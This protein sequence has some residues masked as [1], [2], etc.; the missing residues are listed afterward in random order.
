MKDCIEETVLPVIKVDTEVSPNC[1]LKF[2]YTTDRSYE[3][4]IHKEFITHA[5]VELDD[6]IISIPIAFFA[7]GKFSPYY[8]YITNDVVPLKT[9]NEIRLKVFDVL[10][11]E[12]DTY[13]S[14]VLRNG[15]GRW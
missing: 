13:S 2:I 4:E 14:T 15:F 8:S 7:L 12:N 11:K 9:L 3:S 5:L 10:E 1:R 6:K